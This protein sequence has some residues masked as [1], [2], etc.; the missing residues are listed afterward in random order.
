ME[1]RHL[2]RTFQLWHGVIEGFLDY[3][4]DAILPPGTDHRAL[5]AHAGFLQPGRIFVFFR[6]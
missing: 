4:V 3:G 2:R 6:V 5:D 1:K